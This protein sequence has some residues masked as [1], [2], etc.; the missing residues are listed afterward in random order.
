VAFGSAVGTA[1]NDSRLASIETDFDG[2]PLVGSLVRTIARNQH[3]ESKPDAIRE[4]N[5][6][7][8]SRACREVDQQAEPR[9]TEMVARVRERV[10]Q[11]LVALGLEPTPVALDTTA[12]VAT[13]RLRL[14]GA[15]QLA[16]HTPRPRAPSESLLSAQLHES[17]LN[18]A[19]E[20]FDLAGRRL[21]L[22]D[23]VR[24]VCGKL[25]LP[26]QVPEDLPEDVQV[27]FAAVQPLRVECRD[28]L[29]RL[30]V[31]LDALESGRRSWYEI[32]AGVAYRPVGRGAQVFLER[33]GPVQLSGPGHQGR[34]ELALRTVFGKVFPKERPIAVLPA[35]IVAD[36]RM[37][38]VR[39]VQAVSAD[40]WLAFAIAATTQAGHSKPSSTAGRPAPA[41][42]MLRR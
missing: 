9:F 20:R 8:I 21:P 41:R 2:V 6:R 42:R 28:G 27:T 10:W 35:H 4:V 19:C 31:S 17:S 38:D 29:V 22:G 36:P 11:P 14:A 24:M 3:D 16:A 15:R 18:N 26:P 25:G 32:V 5:A 39:A 40:G 30:R 23:L 13:A 33:E 34:V 7:I 37:A 12:D 1:S